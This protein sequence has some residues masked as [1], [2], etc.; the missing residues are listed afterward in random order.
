MVLGKHI[1]FFLDTGASRSVLTKYEGL[2]KKASFPIEGVNGIA[3]IPDI[4]P[5]LYCISASKSFTHPFLVIPSC[6]FPG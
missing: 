1:S 4:T 2:L 5:L 3:N 6:P